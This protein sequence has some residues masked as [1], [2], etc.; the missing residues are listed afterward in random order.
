MFACPTGSQWS[1]W[2]S[3][4]ARRVRGQG[5]VHTGLSNKPGRVCECLC[6]GKKKAEKLPKWLIK[7]TICRCAVAGWQRIWRPPWSPWRERAQGKYDERVL[8]LVAAQGRGTNIIKGFY[9]SPKIRSYSLLFQGPN[10]HWSQSLPLSTLSLQ[11]HLGWLVVQRPPPTRLLYAP[12]LTDMNS[13]PVVLIRAFDP[14]MRGGAD[15]RTTWAAFNQAW[16][17]VRSAECSVWGILKERGQ[18]SQ[19]GISRQTI[20]PYPILSNYRATRG[21]PILIEHFK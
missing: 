21:R 2:C 13:E 10:P 11:Q 16:R 20:M 12:V 9:L 6:L 5:K 7:L 4:N 19:R 3:R 17:R 14:L 1:W 18:K 15:S 8:G